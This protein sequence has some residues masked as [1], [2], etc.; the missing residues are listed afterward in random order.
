MLGPVSAR[1][2][3]VG[4]SESPELDFGPIL[5]LWPLKG[6]LG[7]SLVCGICGINVRLCAVS[8]FALDEI[9]R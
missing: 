6:T 9:L 7:P 3:R 5:L 1:V 8:T 2:N 4:S